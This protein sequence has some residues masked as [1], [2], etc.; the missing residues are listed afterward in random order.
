MSTPRKAI[1]YVG[2]LVIFSGWQDNDGFLFSLRK[3]IKSK[4]KESATVL[5]ILGGRFQFF[6]IGEF[7]TKRSIK[8][9]NKRH[10]GL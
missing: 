10:T 7:E 1:T 2:I 3:S 9:R 8:A 6:S 4:K 5:E